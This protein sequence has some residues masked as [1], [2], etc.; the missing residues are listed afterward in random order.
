MPDLTARPKRRSL[1]LSF[2]Q[3]WPA[4]TAALE[5]KYY[6]PPVNL[7]NILD[8]LAKPQAGLGGAARLIAHDQRAADAFFQQPDALRNGRRRD[9]QCARRALETAFSNDG[10]QSCQ[11]R[12]IQHVS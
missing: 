7:P 6:A 2:E 9:M 4:P 12:I 8:V 11:C 10:S 1:D 5:V 3:L